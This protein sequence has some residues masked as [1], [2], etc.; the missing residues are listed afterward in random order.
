MTNDTLQLVVQTHHGSLGEDREKVDWRKRYS[1]RKRTM[2][3]V[4]K[5]AKEMFDGWTYNLATKNC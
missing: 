3:E 1:K 4:I 2:D 5:H